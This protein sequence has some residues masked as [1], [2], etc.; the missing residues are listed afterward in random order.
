MTAASRIGLFGLAVAFASQTLTPQATSPIFQADVTVVNVP[1]VVRDRRGG[2]VT[3]LDKSNF[4]LF[5]GGARQDIRYFA[6]Q[7]DIPL[8]VGLLLDTSGSVRDIVQREKETAG[9]FLRQ[10]LRPSDSGM[11]VSFA[12]S[13]SLWQDFTSS[14]DQLNAA[15]LKVRPVLGPPPF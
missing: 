3:G 6:R 4:E 8:A 5:D 14:T 13:V 2:L 1:C 12:D 9:T 10:V 15:L 11:V 7:A